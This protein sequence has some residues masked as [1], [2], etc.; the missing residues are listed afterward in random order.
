MVA[1]FSAP[2][3]TGRE[4]YL[5]NGH[6]VSFPG[7][8]RPERDVDHPPLSSAQVKERVGYTSTPTLGLCGLFLDE[9]DFT[10]LNLLYFMLDIYNFQCLFYAIY[11]LH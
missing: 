11:T 8:K 5:Y 6:Q 1:R 7:I 3:Q 2:V 10:G 9:L 4:A